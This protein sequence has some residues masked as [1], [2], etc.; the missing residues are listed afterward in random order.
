MQSSSSPVPCRPID[1]VIV[2]NLLDLATCVRDLEKQHNEQLENCLEIISEMDREI[3][4]LKTSVDELMNRLDTREQELHRLRRETRNL[5]LYKKMKKCST[6]RRQ[7]RRQ[8]KRDLELL[9]GTGLPE[10]E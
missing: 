8:R 10:S 4:E 1:N 7:T 2:S 5:L 3:N 9:R 6:V